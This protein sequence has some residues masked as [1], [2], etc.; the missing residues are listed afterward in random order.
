MVATLILMIAGRGIAQLITNAIQIVIF[1]DT[2]AY[3]GTASSSC[4][5]PCSSS[6]RPVRRC[7]AA[8][9]TNADRPVRGIGRHQLP[10]ELLQR[11]QREAGQAV[12]LRVLRLLRRR[13]RPDRRVEHPD[14]RR[15]QDRAVHRAGRDPGRRHRRDAPGT[16]G[17]FS[18]LGSVIGALVLQTTTRRCSRSACRERHHRRQ[19][20][21]R[22][23][24]DPALRRAG[25]TLDSRAGKHAARQGDS[26]DAAM[27][28]AAITG[29]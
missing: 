26:D 7:L 16:G 29:R 5:S 20:G 15:Q 6:P 23:R 8:D 18:L 1:N 9:A 28:P 12:R 13:R 3:I 25:K 27:L 24:R 22:D 19:G 10:G 17:R 4:P 11:H 14:L 21:R 2:Y